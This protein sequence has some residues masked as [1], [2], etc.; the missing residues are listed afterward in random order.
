MTQ[1]R[2]GYA[3]THK[4]VAPTQSIALQSD[5]GQNGEKNQA[6][7]D[8]AKPK[9]PDLPIAESENLL[10]H[11]PPAFRREKRQQA[12]YHKHQRQC[13]QKAVDAH[14]FVIDD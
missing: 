1:N 5:S 11:R 9:E 14:G 8:A 4:V 6:G 7:R 3:R 2:Y 13:L 12:F 10:K